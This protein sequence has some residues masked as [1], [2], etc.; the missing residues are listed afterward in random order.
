MARVL[1]SPGRIE[2]AERENWPNS[3]RRVGVN[4]RRLIGYQRTCRWNDTPVLSVEQQQD[5]CRPITPLAALGCPI[6]LR[7]PT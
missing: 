2:R 6:Y 5:G 4:H 3:D 1:Y 7:L